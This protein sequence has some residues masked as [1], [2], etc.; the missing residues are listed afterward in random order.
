MTVKAKEK[1]VRSRQIVG[2]LEGKIL[3]FRVLFFF[4]TIQRLEQLVVIGDCISRSRRQIV[5]KCREPKTEDGRVRYG[6]SVETGTCYVCAVK[7][8]TE[9]STR[10]GTSQAKPS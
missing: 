8:E 1:S 6:S 4:E 3:I 9:T 2:K 10:I 5:A 7:S